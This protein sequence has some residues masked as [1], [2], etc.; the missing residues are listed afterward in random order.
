VREAAIQT[1][2]SLGPEGKYQ[3]YEHFLT[4]PDR[5]LREQIVEVL[6]RTG[7]VSALVEEYSAGT[8]GVDALIVEQLAGAAAPLGLSGLLHTLDPEIRQK[9]LHRL[10][11]D[12]QSK[13]PL[14][15]ERG[16]EVESAIRLQRVHELP[17]F[18]AA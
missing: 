15:E 11:P 18:R 16:P 17:P 1:L 14:P 2:L 13:M 7:L 4:S 9:F 3:L 6:E 8:N 10:I 12:A 5:T